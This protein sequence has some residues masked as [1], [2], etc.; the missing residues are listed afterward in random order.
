LGFSQEE[1]GFDTRIST[2]V[3]QNIATIAVKTFPILANLRVVRSW[4]A[5]RVMT[6]D[7]MPIYEASESFPG[8]VTITLHSGVSLA[9]LHATKIAPWVLEGIPPEGFENFSSRRFHV[10]TAS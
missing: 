3:I 8:A 1:M 5:L 6:P 10:Q 7:A 9:A 2:D 4:A